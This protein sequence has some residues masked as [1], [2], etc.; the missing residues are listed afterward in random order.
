M[1]KLC[2]LCGAALPDDSAFC[3]KCGAKLTD[4]NDSNGADSLGFGVA[5][6]LEP[7]QVFDGET[8]T[9]IDGKDNAS[10][11][12]E[13]EAVSRKELISKL[14]EIAQAYV[15]LKTLQFQIA[16]MAPE[17]ADVQRLKVLLN[18]NPQLRDLALKYLSA[19][20]K[21]KICNNGLV[22]EK[23]LFAISTLIDFIK[24]NIADDLNKAIATFIIYAQ[25]MLQA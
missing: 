6:A 18:E 20:E 2:D 12:T 4:E 5:V 24:A 22:P 11:Q 21:L 13:E 10:V 1:S 16:E 23:Y 9:V 8:G 17:G 3:N 7:G 25:E 14:E 19:E 15:E